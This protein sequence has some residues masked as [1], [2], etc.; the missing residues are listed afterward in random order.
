MVDRFIAVDLGVDLRHLLQRFDIGVAVG[1]GK[2][3]VVP[4]IRN[5]ERLSFAEVESTIGDYAKRA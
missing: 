1:G 3:L 4:V 2:G 5:A